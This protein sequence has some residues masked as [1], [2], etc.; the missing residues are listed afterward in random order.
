M[1][2]RQVT[3]LVEPPLRLRLIEARD[4]PTTRAWRN[5]DDVRAWLLTTAPIT[6]DQ[7]E[8]WFRQY[9][10]RD[11]DFV[12]IIEEIE[13]LCRPIGQVAIYHVDWA[14]RSA[15]F[16]RLMIG[17]PMA[18]GRGFAR[19]A[20]AMVIRLAF[21]QWRLRRLSLSVKRTNARAVSIY[22][23]NGFAID[24]ET[25]DLVTMVLTANRSND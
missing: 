18:R 11:D 19:Q 5:R 22:Q 25:D 8:A 1:A 3:P 21:D 16:G 10:E 14:A 20:T 9:Q 23:S 13:G 15:E 17:E 6:A 12:F 7:H 2:K 24:V 4:L